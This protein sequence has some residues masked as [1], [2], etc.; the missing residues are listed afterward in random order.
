MVQSDGGA[1]GNDD[2][3]LLAVELA[4]G[5]CRRQDAVGAGRGVSRRGGSG[6]TQSFRRL[7]PRPCLCCEGR[8]CAVDAEAV[9]AIVPTSQIANGKDAAAGKLARQKNNGFAGASSMRPW[10]KATH[11]LF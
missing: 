8:M 9:P 7:G 4:D 11:G 10:L 3:F 1:S 5:F 2:G 6:T